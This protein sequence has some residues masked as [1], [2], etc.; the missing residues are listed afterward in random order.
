MNKC[1]ETLS[2]LGSSSWTSKGSKD[3]CMFGYLEETSSCKDKE[4]KRHRQ[5]QTDSE[6]TARERKRG[7]MNSVFSM[8]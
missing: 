1:M 3:I 4:R 6:K 5:G 7:Q 2:Y 8:V